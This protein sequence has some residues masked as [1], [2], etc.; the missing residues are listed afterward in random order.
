VLVDTV[1]VSYNSVDHLRSCVEP[2]VALPQ[3]TLT[4]VDSAS[5]DESLGSISDLPV[6][7]VALPVNRGFA[8]ACNAG[9][10]RGHSPFVLFLNPDATLDGDSLSRMVTAA[11]RS[12]YVGVVAPRIVEPGGTLD[13]SLRRFPRLRST[14]SQALFLHRLFPRSSWS[15]ELERDNRVYQ[16][17]GSPEWAS[18][19]CLLIRRA[20]LE[21]VGGLDEGFFLY[22]EDLDLCRRLRDAGYDIRF[23]PDAVAVHEGG[24][25]APRSALLPVLAA[26]RV[27]YARLHQSPAVAFLE[28]IGIAI[29]ALTHMVVSRGGPGAR[30]GWLRALGLALSPRPGRQPAIGGP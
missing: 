27:R 21:D 2:L 19:A 17:P 15:D 12:P 22:C 7:T 20:A 25:S 1:I 29:G 4:V 16:Q 28:R 5:S 30:K 14:Y 8:H 26:S 10:R 6:E 24:A 18:G 11:E 3:V 13:Y 23:E 9:W